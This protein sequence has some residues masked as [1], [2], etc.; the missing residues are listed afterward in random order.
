MNTT[1]KA[2]K[3]VVDPPDLDLLVRRNI[4]RYFT[5][6]LVAFASAREFVFFQQIILHETGFF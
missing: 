2:K 1:E 3:T 5:D 4:F 6:I